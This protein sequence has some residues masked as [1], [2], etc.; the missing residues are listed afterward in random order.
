MK[1]T[2]EEATKIFVNDLT[3][4]AVL[5][6]TGVI[7]LL[8]ESFNDDITRL[9]EVIERDENYENYF[10]LKDD[11]NYVSIKMI[12]NGLGI[13]YSGEIMTGKEWINFLGHNPKGYEYQWKL[14][15]EV[16][17]ENNKNY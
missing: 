1:I 5:A 8:A 9:K 12:D 10:G 4:S 7:E 15:K 11:Q 3:L 14:K 2:F 16:K 13:V 17:N 6:T